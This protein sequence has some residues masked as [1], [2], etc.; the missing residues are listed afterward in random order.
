MTKWNLLVLVCAGLSAGT[1]SSA[2][3]AAGRKGVFR[4]TSSEV[5]LETQ[6]LSKKTHRAVTDLQPEDF[7]VYEDGVQQPLASFSHDERPL[8]LIFLFDLTDSV[9]PVLQSLARGALQ[10]LVQLRA[11]DEAAVMVY[12][13]SA[14]LVQDFTTDHLALAAAIRKAAKM[15]SREAAFF[16]QAL[17]QASQQFSMSGSAARRRVIIWL[18]DNIPNIPSEEVRMQFGRSVPEGHLHTEKQTIEELLR[19]GAV[20]YT[21]LLTSSISDDAWVRYQTQPDLILGARQYPPG[22]AH[23]YS[24]KTG[25]EVV[26]ATEGAVRRRIA[27]LIRQ[28][29]ERY[30]LGFRPDLRDGKRGFRRVEVKMNPAVE[31]REGP[32]IIEAREGY[33]R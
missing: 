22:D 6:V 7:S 9:H 18:T 14:T 23:K 15:D 17:F 20:V 13:A 16:N 4:V 12:S 26:T 33:Y 21:L 8:S 24:Q 10:T 2:Q 11:D 31:K 28:I 32:L 30:T 5:Q 19:G 1:W 29:R 3:S 25:G 27:E